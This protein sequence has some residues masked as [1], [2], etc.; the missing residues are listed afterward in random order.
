MN[1]YMNT[2]NLQRPGSMCFTDTHGRRRARYLAFSRCH[3]IK[4]CNDDIWCAHNYV[5]V[6]LMKAEMPKC[7]E[8]ISEGP[9]R[10]NSLY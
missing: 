2:D 3:L 6:H 5:R 4:I 9:F 7:L 8:Y 1:M 10:S